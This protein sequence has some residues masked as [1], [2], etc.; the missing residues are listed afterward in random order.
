MLRA[1]AD[2]SPS[3]PPFFFSLAQFCFVAMY[4]GCWPFISMVCFYFSAAKL[5]ADMYRLLKFNRRARPRMRSQAAEW[6]TMMQC[7]VYLSIIVA[8]ALF[9][10][11]TGQAEMWKRLA[12]GD[13]DE[14]EDVKDKNGDPLERVGTQW[15]CMP[16]GAHRAMIFI[17]LEHIGMI[18]AWCILKLIPK[19]TPKVQTELVNDKKL[20]LRRWQEASVPPAPPKLREDLKK[21]F[22]LAD[23][24]GD[25]RISRD[26]FGTLLHHLSSVGDLGELDDNSMDLLMDEMDMSGNGELTLTEALL[27][28]MRLRSDVVI[29]RAF[30]LQDVVAAPDE[31]EINRAMLTPE[32][33]QPVKSALKQTGRN[34]GKGTGKKASP[35]R[36][37]K[38]R[39]FPS[40]DSSP[41]SEGSASKPRPRRSSASDATGPL[42]VRRRVTIVSKSSAFHRAVT[43]AQ[44]ADKLKKTRSSG[45]VFLGDRR[46]L[47]RHTS[48]HAGSKAEH[49]G[50]QHYPDGGMGPARRR[51]SI[52]GSAEAADARLQRHASQGSLTRALSD[53]S[54]GAGV[55]L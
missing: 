19:L 47:R 6:N 14:C 36:R 24:N 18:S 15:A 32:Q 10:V 35:R 33:Q 20:R 13:G 44:A 53:L 45:S 34:S 8:S 48:F 21:A 5:Y 7:S 51:G 31:A 4:S 25:G 49:A 40:R 43:A 12:P 37:S 54:G 28:I 23:V 42:G 22:M 30:G 27:G 38:D 55:V 17:L 29:Q 16:S 9:A 52:D 11:S 50:A 2:P 3:S 46:A 39:Q 1:I 41:R 26:E